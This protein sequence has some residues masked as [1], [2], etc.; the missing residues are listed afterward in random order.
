MGVSLQNLNKFEKLQN[1]ALKIIFKTPLRDPIT[2]LYCRSGILKLN[3][4]F[5]F[6]VAK[7]MHQIIHKKLPKTL[8]YT[9]HIHLISQ[10]T[11]LVR[12]MQTT[13]FYLLFIL[14]ERSDPQNTL[15]VNLE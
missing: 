14:L 15:A 9:L 11:L 5:N 6:E 2:P 8:N 10:H 1:K 4:L 12:N 13:C 3:D 7:L